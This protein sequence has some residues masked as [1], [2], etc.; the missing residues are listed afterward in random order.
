MARRAGIQKM[1]AIASGEEIDESPD[2]TFKGTQ[3]YIS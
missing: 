3:Y 1:M 2:Y